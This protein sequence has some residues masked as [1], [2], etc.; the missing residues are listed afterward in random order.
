MIN[1]KIRDGLLGYD[2]EEFVMSL[3]ALIV[4][5]KKIERD[6]ALHLAKCMEEHTGTSEEE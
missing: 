1:K 5:D 3:A 4:K 2:E 6:I